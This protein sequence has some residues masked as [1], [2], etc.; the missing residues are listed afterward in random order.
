MICVSTVLNCNE[1]DKVIFETDPNFF[2]LNEVNKLLKELITRKQNNQ[3]EELTTIENNLNSLLSAFK[4]Q[5]GELVPLQQ[6][7]L[8]YAS[9]PP[10][11]EAKQAL[12]FAEIYLLRLQLSNSKYFQFNLL[13]KKD[14]R[15]IR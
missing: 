10:L 12:M 14:V 13:Q 15:I 4:S 11:E 1:L 3:R 6:N 7:L 8:C 5:Y 9:D 2:A